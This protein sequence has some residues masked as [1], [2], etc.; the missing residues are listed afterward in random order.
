MGIPLNKH[1]KN[2]KKFGE[3]PIRLIIPNWNKIDGHTNQTS[4][5]E[6]EWSKK[7]EGC[8]YLAIDWRQANMPIPN[9]A[10]FLSGLSSFNER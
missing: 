5:P 10:S 1:G 8:S 3:Q 9:P 2:L 4:W 6:K 7:T